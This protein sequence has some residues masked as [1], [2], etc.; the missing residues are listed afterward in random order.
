MSMRP[1]QVREQLFPQY[2]GAIAEEDGM[3][4]DVALDIEEA[5]SD[6]EDQR[7]SSAHS[8]ERRHIER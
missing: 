5:F 1:A 7:G 6:A 2:Y 8:E 3:G 4:M